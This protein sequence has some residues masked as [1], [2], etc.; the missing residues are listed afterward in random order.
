MSERQASER[1]GDI[2]QRVGE[3]I[4]DLASR[5]AV[6]RAFRV[7]HTLWQDD[8]TEV[9]DRLGWLQSP[10][11]MAE[12][13]PE[14]DAFAAKCHADGLRHAVLMGM[15]GSSLFPEVMART[16]PVADDR[17][18]LHVLDTTDP[19]AVRRVATTC[20]PDETLFVAA[21]KSGTTIET[22]SHLAFF[23]ERIGRPEHF[24][25]ITDPGSRLGDL[26]RQRGFRAVFENRPDIGG[27]YSALSYFGLVPAALMGVDVT[28]MLRSAESM[29]A[30]CGAHVAV[31]DNPAARLGAVMGAG[32]KAGRDKLTLVLPESVATF[33][34]WLEQLIAESTGKHG[35]G[36]VPIAGE[37]LGPPDV[38]GDD[39]VFVAF[40]GD[41]RLDLLAAAGH[42]VVVLDSPAGAADGDPLAL[43]GE[44]VRWELAT[45]MCG[46]VLGINPFDQPNVAEAKSA[47]NTVLDKGLPTI[48]TTPVAALLEQVEPGDYVAIQAYVDPYDPVVEQLERARMVLRDRLRVATTFG[49]GP[50]FLHSTGQLHKGGPATGVFVQIVGRDESELP[51]PGAPYG[52]STLKRAQAAGDLETLQK[53]GLRAGRVDVDDL[54]KEVSR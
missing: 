28:G 17:L 31:R 52:F 7:D 40:A 54:L 21:S 20:P 15:G 29:L 33:G 16:F 45:A 3:A 8:P 25:V 13:V 51:I 1:L 49:L 23:W 50:R 41:P 32:V 5:D 46:A 42:A 44:V 26:G 19:A 35:T 39:P 34:L 11:E 9:A 2:E 10:A 43:G 48:A 36:V 27:R 4:D 6:A 24:A 12:V 18:Q 38:Y 53:H 14:L 30:A 22:T 37:P 47:T